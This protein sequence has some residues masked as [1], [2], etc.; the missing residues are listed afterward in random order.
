MVDK[1]R[2]EMTIRLRLLDDLFKAMN[3]ERTTRTIFVSCFLISILVSIHIFRKMPRRDG[4]TERRRDGETER[5][6]D[7]ETERRRDR[8]MEG[9]S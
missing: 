9:Q 5:R 8:Y 6:T 4:E 1:T 7:G 2:R 3:L